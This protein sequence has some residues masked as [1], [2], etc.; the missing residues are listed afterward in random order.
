MKMGWISAKAEMKK[1]AKK[2]FI[3]RIASPTFAKSQNVEWIYKNI[4]SLRKRIEKEG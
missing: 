1:K 4:P 3:E 2:E